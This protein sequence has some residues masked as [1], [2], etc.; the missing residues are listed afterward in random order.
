MHGDGLMWI[1]QLRGAPGWKSLLG[2]APASWGGDS[3]WT[4]S[5]RVAP[6]AEAPRAALCRDI[7]GKGFWKQPV[8]TERGFGDPESIASPCLFS[9]T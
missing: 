4:T 3:A 1:K 7:W 6:R 9:L 2:Y 8:Q 5:E